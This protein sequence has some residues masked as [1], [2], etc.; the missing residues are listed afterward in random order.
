MTDGSKRR[1]SADSILDDFDNFEFIEDPEEILAHKLELEAIRDEIESA[2]TPV[3]PPL[4]IG[5]YGAATAAVN[6]GGIQGPAPLPR[7]ALS[8]EEWGLTLCELPAVASLQMSYERNYVDTSRGF[9][10]HIWASRDSSDPDVWN[11][12]QPGVRCSSMAEEA[13]LGC[14]RGW[15]RSPILREEVCWCKA[16]IQSSSAEGEPR[17]VKRLSMMNGCN[18]RLGWLAMDGL[19]WFSDRSVRAKWAL[20]GCGNSVVDCN[21]D[22]LDWY[23]SGN[24][25]D[26]YVVAAYL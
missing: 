23:G 6:R 8:D 18:D 24:C 14:L 15:Q 5:Q 3:V 2:D 25:Y 11:M 4:A 7:G 26:W 17:F 22:E 12:P 16:E 13:V 19:C 1:L 20:D 10:A 9:A 21:V